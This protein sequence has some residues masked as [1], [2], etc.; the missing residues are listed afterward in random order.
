MPWFRSRLQSKNWISFQSWVEGKNLG[1]GQ[2]SLHHSGF[3]SA[4]PFVFSRT[5]EFCAAAASQRFCYMLMNPLKNDFWNISLDM[6]AKPLPPL[7]TLNMSNSREAK[8][9]C[10]VL[11]PTFFPTTSTM[12]LYH[13]GL[14]WKT[15]P[16]L[17]HSDWLILRGS[18]SLHKNILQI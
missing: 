7:S 11:S 15:E 5:G 9:H 10:L 17:R 14:P 18:Y 16:W 12:E 8:S 1:L 3:C 4:S 6:E 13:K 2:F